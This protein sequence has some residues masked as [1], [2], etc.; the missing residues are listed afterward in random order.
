M[1]DKM[2]FFNAGEL[3]ELK[4]DLPHKPVMMVKRIVK[5]RKSADVKT[6]FL[7]IKCCWFTSTGDYREQIFSSKDLKH[8]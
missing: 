7:G 3:V 4:Q 5:S 8:I 6:I 2:V 1:K